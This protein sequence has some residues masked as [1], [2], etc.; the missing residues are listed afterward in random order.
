MAP[1]IEP[2]SDKVI[3]FPEIEKEAANL[4]IGAK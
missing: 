3:N 4:K 1:Y 2:P